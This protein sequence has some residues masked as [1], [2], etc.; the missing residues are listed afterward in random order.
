MNLRQSHRKYPLLGVSVNA[1]DQAALVE[2]VRRGI[3]LQERTIV[4]SQ[5]LHG[6]HAFH[7]NEE[8]RRLHE[9]ALVRADGMPLVFW[10]R[11]LGHPFERRH[12]VTWVDWM[13]T[14]MSA[15]A[16]S[17]WRVFHLGGSAQ[18]VARGLA[19]LRETHAGLIVD[20]RDGYF[21]PQDDSR[22]NSAIVDHINEWNPDILLIGMGMPRQERWTL[23]NAARLRCPVLLTCGAALEYFAGTAPV[24]PR[25]TGSLGLEGA[26]RLLADPRRFWK[27]YLIEPW[28]LFP[29]AL[30]DVRRRLRGSK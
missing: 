30:R 19:A 4:V 9:S 13:P 2:I 16:D 10:G 23:R 5:N 1:L 20:G 3:A 14:L 26:Y 15:A 24:P 29:L 28:T 18:T 12:R 11:I 8:M 21:D 25:W 27:R 17:G 22:E 6:I 7:R